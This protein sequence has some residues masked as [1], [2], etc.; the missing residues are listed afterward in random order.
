MRGLTEETCQ[1][2]G[3]GV[4]VEP[5]PGHD[6]YRNRLAIPYVT[7]A[8]V[9]DIR[10]RCLQQHDCGDAHHPKIMG[11]PGSSLRLF[12]VE[13]LFDSRDYVCICEGEFDTL[14]LKQCGLPAVGLPGTQSWKPHYARIF[15]DYQRVYVFGDGDQAGRALGEKLAGE[16]GAIPVAMPAGMDV[17][18]VA[19]CETYGIQWLKAQVGEE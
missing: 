7:R 18:D 4:V 3:L 11:L 13:G 8:G 9:V 10:F 19:L 5:A 2:A 6:A 14:I 17:N 12:H 15:E 16:I 1:S